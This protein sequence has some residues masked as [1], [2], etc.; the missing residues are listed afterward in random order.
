MVFVLLDFVQRQRRARQRRRLIRLIAV[1]WVPPDV[2][3]SGACLARGTRVGV[4]RFTPSRVAPHR[5]RAS[6][7]GRSTP[8]GNSCWPFHGRARWRPR[9]LLG[10]G[11]QKR[12]P[13]PRAGD[14]HLVGMFPSGAQLSVAFAQSYRGLPTDILARLGHLLKAPRQMPADCGGGA[15]GPGAFDQ[16]PA[17]MAVASLSAAALSAPL[18]RRGCRRCETQVVHE[19]SGVIA[20]GE[21]AE[22]GHGGPCDRDLHPA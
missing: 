13:F 21:V 9:D 10:P 18:A 15:R 6:T 2:R 4:S 5:G 8:S 20:P 17:G 12:T 1:A 16:R 11:P 22:F 14:D 19:L 7:A 3:P